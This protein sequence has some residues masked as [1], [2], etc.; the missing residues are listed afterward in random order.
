VSTDRVLQTFKVLQREMKKSGKRISLPR[1]TA[2]EKTYQYRAISKFLN[3]VD[4]W[5]LDAATT[6]ILIQAVVEYGRRYGLL[7]KGAM[8]LNMENILKICYNKLDSELTTMN[9]LVDNVKRANV[10]MK[11]ISADELL[12]PIRLGGYSKLFCLIDTGDVDSVYLALSTKS[13][14]ALQKVS[15][16]EREQLPSNIDLFRIR[17]KIL[18]DRDIALE[19]KEILQ[20][21]LNTS[22]VI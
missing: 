13:F 7:R 17:N 22:G 11:A 16:M 10:V 21:D 19:I 2:P 12:K 8:I 9:D 14:G 1:N 5:G 15:R 20:E 4:E 3:R 6:A 18:R